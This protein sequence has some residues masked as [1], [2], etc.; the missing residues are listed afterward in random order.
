VN[1]L[2]THTHVL[3]RH[4]SKTAY[5]F[6]QWGVELGKKLASNVRQRMHAFRSGKGTIV[7][8]FNP[9]TKSLLKR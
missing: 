9:S 5:S 3:H 8:G 2:N 4:R 1:A 7:S 6:D